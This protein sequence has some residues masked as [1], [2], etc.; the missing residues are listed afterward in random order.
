MKN[1]TLFTEFAKDLDKNSPHNYYPRPQ[2]KR[3]SFISLNG[4]W[5][6]DFLPDKKQ[7]E[8][9]QKIVVPFC[10][11]CALSGIEK[12][13][14]KG[15]YLHYSRTFSVSEDFKKDRIILHFGAVDQICEVYVNGSL[16]GE[17]EGGY[18]PFSFDITD[19]I[20]NE[21]NL[22]YVVVKDD[23][24]NKYPYGKQ[25]DNRGGMWYTPVSGIWQTVWLESIPK[26]HIEG[27]KIDQN[28][29]EVTV[30]V[31]G[32]CGA[33]TFICEDEKIEFQGDTITFCP[34]KKVLWTPDTPKI[35]SFTIITET[36]KIE[37]YF[38]LR[39]IGIT[40]VNG[41]KRLTL[42]GKPYLFNGLL[43]QGYY[44]DG[45]FLP[46][47][48]EGYKND[49]LVAKNLGFNMLRKHIKIE[50]MIFYYLCDTLGMVVF[51]D[52]VNNSDYS[53]TR[54]TV[55]PT[56]GIQKL[57][58]KLLHRNK[59]SRN[60][61]INTMFKIAEHL[62]NTPSILYYTIFNEGWGQFNA[63]GMYQKLK[64]FDPTRIIDST[65]GWFR[66]KKSDVDSRHIY[67]KKL[68]I[69]K[70]TGAP[71]SLSEFGGYA[72][73]VEGHLFGE[74]N[75][76]YKSFNTIEEFEQAFTNLYENQVIDVVKKGASALVYTQLSDVED[77]TNGLMTYDRK[78]VKLNEEK[79]AAL[80][81]RI[82]SLPD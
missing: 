63:D 34:K 72:H 33:K 62:Y 45:L 46:A 53:F 4:E 82:N 14:Q 18:L 80:M 73:R 9:T 35:Y 56:I 47:T 69:K 43:D 13:H 6:F 24:D 79:C 41:I 7:T 38:A 39:E 59:E 52:M 44:S 78:V 74:N 48:I 19:L 70:P 25:T 58:D 68:K 29:S 65:S 5:D 36:D 67:F 51:Q 15:E 27:I 77:E 10:P 76:G 16:A 42:N 8:L 17:N 49:I 66:R 71:I 21:E 61:F 31:M 40:E 20:N 81:K 55:L 11:E 75:Y 37:S 3:D 60:I 26:N 30:R 64:A 12:S 57:S 32:E 54:D 50:P 22:L 1:K 2:F 23:L 28:A